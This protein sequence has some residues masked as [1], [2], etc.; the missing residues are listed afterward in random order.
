MK[1][2]SN[3]SI[4]VCDM[5]HEIYQQSSGFYCRSGK[6]IGSVPLDILSLIKIGN[7]D[8]DPKTLYFSLRVLFMAS[9]IQRKISRPLQSFTG[10]ELFILAKICVALLRASFTFRMTIECAACS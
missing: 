5:E 7:L 2:T 10:I 8:I 1:A 9:C 6:S 3:K 4:L